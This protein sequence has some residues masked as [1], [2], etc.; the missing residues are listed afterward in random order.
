M[1]LKRNIDT[2]LSDWKNSH[3]KKPLLLRGARQ[4]GKSTSV[5]A[6]GKQFEYFL[7]VNFEADKDVHAFFEG[8]IN[9]WAVCPK[10]CRSIWM[11]NLF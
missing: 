6:F 2:I 3:S 5:R 11:V 1:Q 9:V 10:W 4:V 8:N 7:E